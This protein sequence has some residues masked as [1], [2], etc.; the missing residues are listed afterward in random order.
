V[1]VK[2]NSNFTG[3]S[4]DEPDVL[5]APSD[6]MAVAR[7][8]IE[9]HQTD[10]GEVTLRHW[11]NGW[12]QWQGTHWIEAA[13]KA[14]RSWLYARLEDA[15]YW[16]VQAATKTR[17][18]ISE[19]RRWNPNRHKVAD[20]L[21][22]LAAVAHTAEGIDPPEIAA[23]LEELASADASMLRLLVRSGRGQTLCIAHEIVACSNGLLHVG[24]RTPRPDTAVLQPSRGAVRVR[25]NR[26]RTSP[27]AAIPQPALA[28]MT[29]SRLPRCRSSSATCYLDGP[30]CTRSCS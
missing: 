1:G 26:T 23:G 10:D 14:I 4:G 9:D 2:I 29:Q 13:D 3:S 7:V 25:A 30:T 17:E 27:L 15:Q 24:T 20:V 5:P 16:Y 8:L 18:E 22:A 21:D 12:M 19:L 28:P 11:R 6:P